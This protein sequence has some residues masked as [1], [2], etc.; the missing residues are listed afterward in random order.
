V[1]NFT[2]TEAADVPRLHVYFYK[3]FT[4]T[5]AGIRARAAKSKGAATSIDVMNAEETESVA[6]H[7]IAG[8]GMK[9]GKPIGR[10]YFRVDGSFVTETEIVQEQEYEQMKQAG[11]LDKDGLRKG[12]LGVK[13]F[14]IRAE[15][16]IT[17]TEKTEREE[18]ESARSS[19]SKK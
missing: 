14:E 5:M 7:M 17:M 1:P 4:E 19:D 8:Y 13:M 16:L 15:S 9:A 6:M 10:R 12:T 3:H 2:T 18:E 11:E